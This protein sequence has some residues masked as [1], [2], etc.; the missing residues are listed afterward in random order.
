MI[1]WGAKSGGAMSRQSVG[2]MNNYLTRRSRW[3]SRC[4]EL[5]PE[6]SISEKI[7]CDYLLDNASISGD[8]RLMV[9]TSVGNKKVYKDIEGALRKHHNRIHEGESQPRATR[10]LLVG[11]SYGSSVAMAAASVIPSVVGFAAI[12]Q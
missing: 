11:Y 7:L 9:M 12:G 1:T 6:V 4:K 8:Q 2:A 5:D 10:V 3:W